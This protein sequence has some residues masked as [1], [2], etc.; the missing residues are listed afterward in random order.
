MGILGPCLSLSIDLLSFIGINYSYY[1]SEVG[2]A[3]Q[4]LEKG[5]LEMPSCKTT[6]NFPN[7][8]S[9]IKPLN[10]SFIDN[11]APSCPMSYVIVS[12]MVR[13]IKMNVEWA[14]G[15]LEM[16]GVRSEVRWWAMRDAASITAWL[17]VW[18]S[19]VEIIFRS[20]T[21]VKVP[22]NNTN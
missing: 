4:K 16:W 1:I 10:M 5:V 11:L 22:H 3:M 17:I 13:A 20:F 12:A 8:Q 18:C 7:L 2:S 15:G 19:L 9:S 14:A 21:E 6:G